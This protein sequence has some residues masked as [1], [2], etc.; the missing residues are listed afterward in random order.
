MQSPTPER[1]HIRFT[2]I[3]SEAHAWISASELAGAAGITP[4]TLER[5]VRLGLLHAFDVTPAGFPVS[6]V[7]RLRRMLRLHRQLELNLVAAAMLAAQLE[8]IEQLESELARL[9]GGT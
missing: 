6:A 5:I 4:S 9:R 8:R 7:S 3:T 1:Q 2:T